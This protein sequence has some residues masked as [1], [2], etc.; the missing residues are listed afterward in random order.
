MNVRANNESSTSISV[1]WDR[2]SYPNGVIR[3][4]QVIYLLVDDGSASNAAT[5][6]NETKI[7]IDGLSFYTDYA[8]S[9]RAMTIEFGELSENVTQRTSE[10]GKGLYYCNILKCPVC[11]FSS[12]SS[13]WYNSFQ[14][15]FH[16]H[17]CFM[18]S[19]NKS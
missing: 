10:D 18:G 7:V 17:F 12:L 11:S 1:E 8:L 13:C 14:H 4:Y 5:E 15:Q 3:F 2:P 9:V 19:T 16:L 6:G